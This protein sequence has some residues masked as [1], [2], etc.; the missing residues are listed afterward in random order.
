MVV[1]ET[2]KGAIEIEVDL[3]K[4]PITA[5]ELSEVRRRRVLRRRTVSPHRA[6]RHREPDGLS[7][8]G[9]PG[10]R[11]PG[12]R[13]PRR[14]RRSRWSGRT[15]TGILHKN[16][17]V[18][19]ARG[20][21]RT[22]R[23]ISSSS[24]SAISRSSTSAASA[25]PTGRGSRA[26]GRVIIGMDVVEAIQSAPV[27]KERAGSEAA[28]AEPVA[29]DRDYQG[30]SQVAADHAH[31]RR[32]RR[33]GRPPQ[34]RQQGACARSGIAATPSCRST[35]T[36]P[37]SKASARTRP[38]STIRARSTRRRSTCRRTSARQV[39]DQVAKKGIT[40]VWLNPGADA[41]AGRRARAIARPE[42]DRRVLDSRDRGVAGRLLKVQ[43]VIEI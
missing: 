23:P 39:L 32:H 42:G 20:T 21:P 41:P 30:A 19:M 4:A 5:G 17:V 6:A 35:R 11:Q 37:S 28:D 1:L 22:R 12:A 36:R 13:G 33:V 43:V 8:S 34:V 27:A 24:A 3:A 38:C 40:K 29:A 25:M 10:E 9:H 16:G 15:S 18:S 7:D 14:F 26:F 31:R 2:E